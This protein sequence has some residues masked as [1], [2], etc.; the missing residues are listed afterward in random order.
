MTQTQEL[1]GVLA[2]STAFADTDLA[3][4]ADAVG[5]VT[6]P[7][8]RRVQARAGMHNVIAVAAHQDVIAQTAKQRVVAVAT[9]QD[10]V[11]RIGLDRVVA[12]AAI[13]GIVTAGGDKHV[14]DRVARFDIVS[15]NPKARCLKERQRPAL[16]IGTVGACRL[17]SRV[18][19]HLIFKIGLIF[20]RDLRVVVQL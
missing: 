16:R 5:V 3:E 12:Q 15:R 20:R 4:I 18:I 2:I 8:V 13:D 10:V 6:I 19:G 14:V 7:A 9:A 11:A 1:H 17:N